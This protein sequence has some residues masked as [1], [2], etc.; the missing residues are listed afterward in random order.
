[1]LSLCCQ[2]VVPRFR[3]CYETR[4]AFSVVEREARKTSA[5]G[6]EYLSPAR[7]RRRSAGLSGKSDPSPGGTTQFRNGLFSAMPPGRLRSGVG[8]RN[9]SL[10]LHDF[11]IRRNCLLPIAPM[12]LPPSLPAP[13][14][15]VLTPASTHPA[16]AS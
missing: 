8:R 13:R 16:P 15:T 2:T 14:G 11:L 10:P 3:A 9:E 12:P 7:S 4:Y 1:M 6:T 5:G